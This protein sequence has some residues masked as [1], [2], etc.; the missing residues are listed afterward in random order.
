MIIQIAYNCL[1]E[2]Q[3]VTYKEGNTI[4][5]CYDRK[6]NASELRQADIHQ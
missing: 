1:N 6:W 2:A 5:L 4:R 3:A